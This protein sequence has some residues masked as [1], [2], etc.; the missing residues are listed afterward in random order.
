MGR[1]HTSF[2]GQL[3]TDTVAGFGC[4][5]SLAYIFVVNPLYLAPTGV[6]VG[7]AISASI[8]VSAFATIAM[9]LYA[10][11]PFAVAPGL[12]MNGIFVVIICGTMGFHWQQ[13]LGAVFLSG[14]LTLV[15]ACT[16]YY[17]GLLRTVPRPLRNSITF[18]VGLFVAMTGLHFAGILPFARGVVDFSSISYAHMFSKQSAL[19]LFGFSFC[20]ILAERLR[21]PGGI[22]ISVFLTAIAAIAMGFGKQVGATPMSASLTSSLA[23]SAHILASIDWFT[24]LKS[25]PLFSAVVLLAAIQLFGGFGKYETLAHAAGID[26]AEQRFGR[27]LQVDSLGT[28]LGGMFGTSSLI[29]F[30]ES[31]VGIAMGGRTGFVAIVCGLL[32]LTTLF[33]RDIVSLIPLE[34][35]T[36]I[37][38]FVFYLIAKEVIAKSG[39]LT[40]L[41]WMAIVAMSGSAL[42]FFNLDVPL[43]IGFG[44]Y[45]FERE[46]TSAYYVRFERLAIALGIGGLGFLARMTH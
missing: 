46:P 44:I 34:A 36:G 27:A 8:V 42:L 40:I 21:I 45:F 26:D 29:T 18:V 7:G 38:V 32:M 24:P 10:R 23:D 39:A 11:F 6:P 30:V 22:L 12:E 3:L 5:L 9:G 41:Q 25:L 2:L 1:P 17:R 31:I 4:F 43:A 13:G 28:M 37:L 33:V 15:L 16:P 20:F 35:T 19:L 14:L